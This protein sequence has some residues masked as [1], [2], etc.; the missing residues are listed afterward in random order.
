MDNSFKMK[1]KDH[2]P[3]VWDLPT[4]VYYH[5]ELQPVSAAYVYSC[6]QKYC[7]GWKTVIEQHGATGHIHPSLSPS[8]SPSFIIP[9]TDLTTLPCWVNN[10]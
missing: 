1:Y 8:V 5:I 3:H 2:F 9:K 7:A 4:D 6:P 10:Y